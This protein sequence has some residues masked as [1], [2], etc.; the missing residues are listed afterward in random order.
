MSK[1]GL[2]WL[3]CRCHIRSSYQPMLTALE[4]KHQLLPQIFNLKMYNELVFNLTIGASALYFCEAVMTD[5]PKCLDFV[6]SPCK[7]LLY[8]INV[9]S[10]AKSSIINKQLNNLLI[11]I[12][13]W[14]SMTLCCVSMICVSASALYSSYKYCS[15]LLSIFN[16]Y[17][18]YFFVGFINVRC[19]R[20]NV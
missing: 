3:F 18:Y 14:Y 8:L 6:Y 7:I 10:S 15:F 16:S 1:A 2:Q 4:Q 13:F 19:R 20:Y 17:I 5:K 12:F 9:L 11:L